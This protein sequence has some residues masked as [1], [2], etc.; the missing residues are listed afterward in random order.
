MGR[1][2]VGRFCS[3][4]I[5]APRSEW[6]GEVEGR[7]DACRPRKV[8]G[9]SA[10]AGPGCHPGAEWPGG[11]GGGLRRCHGNGPAGG[12]AHARGERALEPG[13]GRRP[14]EVGQML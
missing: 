12:S 2:V 1:G 10:A 13:L 9:R 8:T 5:L 6:F 14:G 3:V 7:R 11:P 4:A